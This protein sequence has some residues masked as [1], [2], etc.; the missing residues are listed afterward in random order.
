MLSRKKEE[1]LFHNIHRKNSLESDLKKG[2]SGNPNKKWYT[3]T[4]QSARVIHEW[5]K[6]NCPGKKVLD[7]ACGNGKLA[8]FCAKYGGNVVGIDISDVS[9]K[10]AKVFASRKKIEKGVAFLLTD[11]ESL[12]FGDDTFDI[13]YEAG[14]LHHLNLDNAFSELARVLK[15]EGKI[16]CVEALTHNW[17]I[18]KYREKTPNFRTA[19]ETYHIL[20]K[21]HIKMAKYYFSKVEILG[22]YH[23]ATLAIVPFRKSIFFSVLLKFM[24][25]IDWV[26]LKL[27]IVKWQA[28]QVLFVLSNHR[29]LNS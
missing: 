13:I 14:V 18:Q 22:F 17:L 8:I 9:I 3:I 16:L 28:W 12:A 4:R 26:V 24:E 5:L 25:I 6:S 10:N 20:S 15:P 23:L 19:W 7:Y 21:F 11:A 1:K 2:Y 27:P 29:K